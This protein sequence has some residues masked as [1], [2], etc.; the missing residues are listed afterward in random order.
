MI[1]NRFNQ[2]INNLITEAAPNGVALAISGGIDSIA[3]L[4][5]FSE[6]AKLYK[7]KT[8]IFSV[9]HFLR[10]ESAGDIEFVKRQAQILGHDFYS[11]NWIHDSS[12][13]S[14]IQERAR[15]ARYE[16]MTNQCHK[17]NISILITA[18]HKD[19]V[20][21]NYIM[22]LRKKS[23]IFGLSYSCTHFI[24]DIQILR[25]LLIFYK[26]ELVNYLH[27]KKIQWREDCSN[28]SDSYERNR[29]RM[30]ISDFSI[31]Q[32]NQ[33]LQDIH[34]CNIQAQNLNK[35]LLNVIAEFIH[36]TKYGFALI[37]IE[38]INHQT[39]DIKIQ[40]LNYILTII[41]GKKHI[42]RFRSISKI[43]SLLNTNSLINHSLHGCIL[44][45][46]NDKLLV[47]REKKQI[48]NNLIKKKNGFL[49]DNRFLFN[50]DKIDP[51][52]KIETLNINELKK[53]TKKFVFKDLIKIVGNNH[54]IILLTLPVVKNLEKIIAIPHIYYYD[55]IN[56]KDTWQA[57][58]SP[59]F[60]SRFT[61]FL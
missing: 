29:V 18:H 15:D 44:K 20:L 35:Q 50:I 36:I 52:Y 4:Y 16:L 5:L 49:W 25:P 14:A 11:L 47:F 23:G 8:T 54:K 55:D 12:N 6:W 58:F 53:L 27:S 42:P 48:D 46:Y 19:D 43:L 26:D 33:L 24:N 37:N 60:V 13:K 3:L 59:C 34:E 32:K 38:K 1:Q 30:Q 56:F 22:R 40:V 41:S 2:S 51:E 9:N 57:S 39:D 31:D 10:P 7:I 45:T 21:E 61:H 17:L 28:Q